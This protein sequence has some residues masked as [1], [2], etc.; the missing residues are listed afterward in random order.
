[1]VF[2]G[3]VVI[4]QTALFLFYFIFFALF[5]F[6]MFNMHNFEAKKHIS[7]YT[8]YVITFLL[9]LLGETFL[10][11]VLLRH[12]FV[13]FGKVGDKEPKDFPCFACGSN[14]WGYLYKINI[15][16]A[17]PFIAFL[18]ASSIYPPHDCYKCFGKDPDRR[19]S[20]HQYTNEEAEDLEIRRTKGKG[21][22]KRETMNLVESIDIDTLLDTHGNDMDFNPET[23]GSVNS[24]DEIKKRKERMVKKLMDSKNKRLLKKV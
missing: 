10:N 1:M 21:A 5:N 11:W 8:I 2:I 19:F 16:E 6:K 3:M 7:K 12:V 9:A 14:I 18:V 4:T 15:I 17:L 24:E 20:F 22:I 13:Q 23:H